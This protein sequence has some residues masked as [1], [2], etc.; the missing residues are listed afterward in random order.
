MEIINESSFESIVYFVNFIR[1]ICILPKN[2]V[3]DTSK[4]ITIPCNLKS[5]FP[6]SVSL[7]NNYGLS[8]KSVQTGHTLFV[9]KRII[10]QLVGVG[11]E[12]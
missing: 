6:S 4:V 5:P 9:S 11:G 2:P 3:A 12:E 1:R 7:V 10:E 8:S